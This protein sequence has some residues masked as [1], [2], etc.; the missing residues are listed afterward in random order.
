MN[1]QDTRYEYFIT[2]FME[3]HDVSKTG[4]LSIEEVRAAVNFMREKDGLGEASEEEI[5]QVFASL[6]LNHDGKITL[7]EF[8]KAMKKGNY[9]MCESERK[10]K[11]LM[12]ENGLEYK[13][14]LD[15]KILFVEYSTKLFE[16]HDLRKTGSLTIEEFNAC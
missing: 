3:K 1:F 6:D 2:K 8:S 11:E 10:Y 14:I 5:K 12:S 4:S 15:P 13:Q 16:K 9:R 7:E